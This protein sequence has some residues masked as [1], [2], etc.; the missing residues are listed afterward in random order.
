MPTNTRL[1]TPRLILRRYELSEAQRMCDLLADGTVAALVP[2]W[3]EN[4]TPEQMQAMIKEDHEQDE[5][6]V[7]S[8]LGIE[9][10][11]TGELIGVAK[12]VHVVPEHK[13]GGFG[14]WIGTE[15]RSKGYMT[16]AVKAA[17]KHWFETFDFVRMIAHHMQGNDASG[18][19]LLNAGFKEE[20]TFRKHVAH[21]GKYV[22]A[23]FYGIL[24]EELK[25]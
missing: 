1:E 9:L 6:G 12:L 3:P 23:I 15:Y 17:V 2:G 25:Y 14:Y 18:K 4:M 11:K 16:E 7:A 20:G 24:R 19:V 22:D 8:H 5:K 13:H 10:K 21:R